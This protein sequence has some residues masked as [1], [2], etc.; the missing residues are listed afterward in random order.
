MII[1]PQ[2]IINHFGLS[3]S[4]SLQMFVKWIDFSPN[5][6]NPRKSE[7]VYVP[8]GIQLTAGQFAYITI[9]AQTGKSI[10][11]G[12]I[13]VNAETSFIKTSNQRV[14]RTY[15]NM[16]GVGQKNKI[17]NVFEAYKKADEA[18][19]LEEAM[20]RPQRLEM[21]AKRSSGSYDRFLG[22]AKAHEVINGFDSNQVAEIKRFWD[23]WNGKQQAQQQAPQA[24]PLAQ[25][26]FA[27]QQQP[28]Q[29]A[30][31]PLQS[32]FAVQQTQQAAPPA[33]SPFVAQQQPIQAPM[34]PQMAPQA[35]QSQVPQATLEGIYSLLQQLLMSNMAQSVAPRVQ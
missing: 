3:S 4:E 21:L 17:A 22:L 28:A 29:I 31:G 27:V 15:Y 35:F 26:P 32:P 5:Q 30:S 20:P 14:S 10:F 25:S 12:F 19:S 13:F 34:A 16:Y 6:Q 33:Q 1:T 7:Q 24:A 8:N 23:D 2:D 9:K 18:V 11:K